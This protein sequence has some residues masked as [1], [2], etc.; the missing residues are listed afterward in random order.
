MHRILCLDGDATA[1]VLAPGETTIL[2]HICNNQGGWGRG[3]VKALSARWPEPEAAYR[4]W[5][6]GGGEKDPPFELGRVQFVRVTPQIVIA[7]MLAQ[8]G[9]KSPVNPVPLDYDALELALLRVGEVAR[10]KGMS[11]AMPMIGTQ[12]AGGDWK[13]IEALIARHICQQ[14]V[15]VTVYRLM[16]PQVAATPGGR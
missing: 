14:G 9:Y 5:A 12:L 10:K 11:V 16:A 7:N 8:N 3:F 6:R 15:P 13:I 2:A 4:R 1:P